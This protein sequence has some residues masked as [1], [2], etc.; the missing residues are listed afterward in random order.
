M[1]TA[2]SLRYSMHMRYDPSHI[3]TITTGKNHSSVAG[4]MMFALHFQSIS[5]VKTSLAFGSVRFGRCVTDRASGF[6][7]MRWEVTS[8][9]PKFPSYT[10]S[11]FIKMPRRC[12]LCLWRTFVNCR[13]CTKSFFCPDHESNCGSRFYCDASEVRPKSSGAQIA[14]DI[15]PSGWTIMSAIFWFLTGF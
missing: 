10:L 1:V 11:N 5:L 6:R 14:V 8:I 7:L 2:K 3:G 9:S 15:V 13:F 4:L 12:S